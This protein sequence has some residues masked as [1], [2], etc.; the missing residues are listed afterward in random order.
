[1]L[2]RRSTCAS[3]YQA[4]DS[5]VQALDGLSFEAARGTVFGLLGPNGAGKSTTVKILA[6][7]VAP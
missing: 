7:L 1:M 2:C 3:R 5:T 6:T 4:K